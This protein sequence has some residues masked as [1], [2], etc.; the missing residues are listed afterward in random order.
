MEELYFKNMNDTIDY[1]Q[2]KNT[3]IQYK[4]KIIVFRNMLL[5][6]LIE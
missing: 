4:L 5:N 6:K 3:I 2:D 1:L